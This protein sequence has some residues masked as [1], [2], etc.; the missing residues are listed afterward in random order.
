MWTPTAPGEYI[1]IDFGQPSVTVIVVRGTGGVSTHEVI[2]YEHYSTLDACKPVPEQFEGQNRK[3]RGFPSQT[4]RALA[5][6]PEPVIY[7]AP[8]QHYK[9][10]IYGRE[11]RRPSWA[12]RRTNTCS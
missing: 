2:G 7:Q 12:R 3:R 5:P 10:P 4:L 8:R 9:R 11:P 1:G 6:M